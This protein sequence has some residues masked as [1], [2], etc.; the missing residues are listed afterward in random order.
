MTELGI[1]ERTEDQDRDREADGK[2]EGKLPPMLTV[3][4]LAV[5]LRVNRKT[6]YEMAT[7][8]ELPGC[9]RIGRTL[10]ISSKAISDWLDGSISARSP[11]R[12]RRL[13]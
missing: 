2:V 5:Y 7:R 4:E 10:R 9:V 1:E 3:D 13:K 11:K 6:I 8:G 12:G